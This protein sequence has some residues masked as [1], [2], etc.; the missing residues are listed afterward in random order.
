MAPPTKGRIRQRI[1]RGCAAA[2]LVLAALA[3]A[4]PIPAT[5]RLVTPVTLRVDEGATVALPRG[6]GPVRLSSD[7]PI[8][9]IPPTIQSPFGPSRL[10]FA[11]QTPASEG[12]A[13]VTVRKSQFEQGTPQYL[14]TMR[15]RD[16]AI[17]LNHMETRVHGGRPSWAVR[18]VHSK[19]PALRS[20]GG[21]RVIYWEGEWNTGDNRTAM[22]RGYAFFG[23]GAVYLLRVFG[24]AGH[25]QPAFADEARFADAVAG[26]F[27]TR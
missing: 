6:W 19:P 23:N 16:L 25:E 22:V 18:L 14:E 15:P 5:P 21:R 2:W 7:T 27:R 4:R 26:T 9:S 20:L 10:V 8:P 1:C 13:L 3:W 17:L 24:T 11:Q 12:F